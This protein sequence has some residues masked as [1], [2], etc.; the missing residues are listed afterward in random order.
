VN[1]KPHAINTDNG[2]EFEGEFAEVLRSNDINIR[3]CKP[4]TPQENGKL[5]RWWGN[6][7]KTMKGNRNISKFV[8]EYNNYWSHYGLKGMGFKN[9]TPSEAWK[10][11][12]H[13]EGKSDLEYDYYTILK[14]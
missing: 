4:R 2:K 3:K 8:N 14:N 9:M 10:T 1:P 5:E 13:Y 7:E 11:M 6:F 12:P